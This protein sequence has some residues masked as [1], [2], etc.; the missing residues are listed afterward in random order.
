MTND[1]ITG[2]LTATTYWA[3]TAKGSGTDKPPIRRGIR[4]D[5]IPMSSWGSSLANLLTKA[6]WDSVR[7]PVLRTAGAC[8]VCTEATAPLECHEIW[9][10]ALPP[11]DAVPG[12]VGV[13]R[14][15]GLAALCEDCHAMFHMGR[16]RVIGTFTFVKQ[17]LMRVNEWSQAE[18]MAYEIEQEELAAK[19]SAVSWALDVSR[20]AGGP[21]LVVKSSWSLHAEGY[22]VGPVMYNE[23]PGFSVILG[24]AYCVG[25]KTISAISTNEAMDGLCPEQGDFAFAM[26]MTRP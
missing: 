11:E 10:Y 2:G 16:A 3:K 14:L 6:S 5:L 23:E 8:Q 18:F 13:Q 25:G 19:R 24:A 22:L 9:S 15:L 17:R 4:P 7:L 20:L 1:E 26:R 21:P 12:T